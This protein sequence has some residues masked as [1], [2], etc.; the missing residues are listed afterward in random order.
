[1]PL[2]SGKFAM[3][4]PNR[5]PHLVSFSDTTAV[6]VQDIIRCKIVKGVEVL[7][8]FVP[9]PRLLLADRSEIGRAEVQNGDCKAQ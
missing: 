1:M 9:D 5:S 7:M 4:D 8:T 2:I 6:E 3:C